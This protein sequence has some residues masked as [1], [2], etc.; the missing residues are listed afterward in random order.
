M[1][2]LN[3]FIKQGFLVSASQNFRTTEECAKNLELLI[4]MGE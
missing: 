1:C 4:S 2:L 3:T